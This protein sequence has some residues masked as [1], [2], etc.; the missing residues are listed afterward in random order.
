M[1]RILILI[2]ALSLSTAASAQSFLDA[3]KGVANNLVNTAVNQATFSIEGTWV[4]QG[5][6]IQLKSDDILSSVA[7][8]TAVSTFEQKGNEALEKAG[9]KAGV[10]KLSF[11]ADGTFS[12]QCG[13]I[14][15][16]GTW[17]SEDK[18]VTLSLKKPFKLEMEGTIVVTSKGC[19]LVFPAQKFI[20]FLD[21]VLTV[22][23]KVKSSDTITALQTAVQLL[24]GAKMG[25]ALTKD[26]E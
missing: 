21:K 25:F 10:A 20:A 24:D 2:C 6:A 12:L 4:Y 19:D 18:Q 23:A 13:K 9:I 16:P 17:T 3:L 26:N 22:V 15:I 7:A 14:S 5:V 1:K 8:K 11:A